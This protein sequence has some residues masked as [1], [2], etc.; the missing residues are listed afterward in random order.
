MGSQRTVAVIGASQDRHKFGNKAVR[1]YRSEG[2]TV[3]PVNPQQSDIEGLATYGSILD[4]PQPVLRAILYV[5]PDIVGSLLDAIA[6]HGVQEIFF[7]PG[8]ESAEAIARA[9]ELGIQTHV[10]CA[11]VAIGRSPSHPD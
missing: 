7:N 8:T 11:I 2:W 1:A 5:Q 10:A 6:E 3:Y 4:V 9:Q